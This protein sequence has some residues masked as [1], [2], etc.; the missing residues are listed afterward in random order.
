MLRLGLCTHTSVHPH[1]ALPWLLPTCPRLPCPPGDSPQPCLCSGLPSPAHIDLPA[2]PL[3]PKGFWGWGRIGAMP[4][5]LSERLPLWLGFGALGEGVRYVWAPVV[6]AGLSQPH[7]EL[8]PLGAHACH[9]ISRRAQSQHMGVHGSGPLQLGDS[10]WETAMHIH[11]SP[12]VYN[13]TH[14]CVCPCM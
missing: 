12:H 3:S 10:T 4:F 11:A 9:S 14:L 13:R 5:W 8:C 2:D 6:T 1:S 7:S